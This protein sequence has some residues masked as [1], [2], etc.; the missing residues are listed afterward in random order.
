MLDDPGRSPEFQCDFQFGVHLINAHIILLVFLF[1]S[2]PGPILQHLFTELQAYP[3]LREYPRARNAPWNAEPSHRATP[4]VGRPADTPE[5]RLHLASLL[6]I[7]SGLTSP[8]ATEHPALR[9]KWVVLIAL[10]CDVL[11]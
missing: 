8:A 4:T 9:K 6:D 3:T 5:P 10:L 2:W 7:C 11:I 1:F